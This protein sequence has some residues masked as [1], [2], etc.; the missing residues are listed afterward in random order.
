MTAHSLYAA[1]ARIEP[2]D[3]ISQWISISR[4]DKRNADSMHSHS[5]LLTCESVCTDTALITFLFL[6]N[7]VF[8][9]HSARSTESGN[10]FD[11]CWLVTVTQIRVTSWTLY[12]MRWNVICRESLQFAQLPKHENTFY[13]HVLHRKIR[14]CAL[15]RKA[16]GRQLCG[17]GGFVV[18][19]PF[20]LAYARRVV[21]QWCYG[22][23]IWVQALDINVCHCGQRINE[24]CVEANVLAT[25][26]NPHATFNWIN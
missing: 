20:S 1:A 5:I 6:F 24:L 2:F 26:V 7:L 10:K 3:R 14:T 17:F 12:T 22:I 23:E 9:A 15:I 13:V 19:S 21:W 25:S 4:D 16:F 8:V 18:F 11:T